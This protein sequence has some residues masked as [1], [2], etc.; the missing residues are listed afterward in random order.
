MSAR[1]VERDLEG[2]GHMVICGPGVSILLLACFFT[3]TFA[4]QR[5]LHPRFLAGFKVKRV[6]LDF[7]NDVFLLHFSFETTQCVFERFAFLQSDFCQRNYTP[8][9]VLC[10][11]VS[12]C[13]KGG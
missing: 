2:R 10:G 9:P 3:S 12:Y 7:L 1:L 8:K 6:P 13:K 4:C 5:F 11:L